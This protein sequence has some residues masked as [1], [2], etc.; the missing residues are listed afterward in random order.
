MEMALI[1]AK[2]STCIRMQTGAVIVSDDRVISI[3]YNG[4]AA[5]Q[6]HCIDLWA[7]EDLK[8]QEFLEKHHKWALLHEIHGEHNAILWAAKKGISTENTT[9]YS[10]YSPCTNC[11]KSIIGSGIKTVY[12][13]NVYG[14][15]AEGI[16]LLKSHGIECN[17]L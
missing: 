14:R 13:K 17:Q 9:M 5:N 15:D 7:H 12:Y 16:N 4:V 2:R 1:T 11:A 6:P 10:V 8:S 3:G